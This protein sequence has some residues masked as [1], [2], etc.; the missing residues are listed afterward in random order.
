[1]KQILLTKCD[2]LVGQFSE[3]TMV[4]YRAG[5]QVQPFVGHVDGLVFALSPAL[6]L[7]A[8]GFARCSFFFG[9]FSSEQEFHGTDLRENLALCLV[10]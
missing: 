7:V 6:A 10:G 2:V 5:V 4:K 9:D 1:M 3:T 8:V